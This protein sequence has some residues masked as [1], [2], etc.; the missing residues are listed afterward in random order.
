MTLQSSDLPDDIKRELLKTIRDRVGD[1]EYNR[2]VDVMG[3]DWVVDAVIKAVDDKAHEVAQEHSLVPDMWRRITRPHLMVYL[4]VS[5]GVA[6]R[7]RS[8]DAPPRWWARAACRLELARQEADLYILTDALTPQEVLERTL[9]F[10][11]EGQV[12][13]V[14][15]VS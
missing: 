4:D 14:R 6:C 12:A 11:E 7:R 8:M 3:E 13:Q 2:M 15:Q 5:P 10:L 1:S 9:R